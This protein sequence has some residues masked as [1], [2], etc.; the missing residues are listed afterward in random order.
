MPS[1]ASEPKRQSEE[2]QGYLQGCVVRYMR[3]TKGVQR[4]SRGVSY[5]QR[6]GDAF[7]QLR[8]EFKLGAVNSHR[9][10][11]VTLVAVKS[12]YWGR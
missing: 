7:R 12:H 2:Y 8:G 5:S 11:E 9:G 4:G 1:I 10:G 6:S 3:G